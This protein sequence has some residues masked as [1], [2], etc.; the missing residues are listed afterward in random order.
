MVGILTQEV[1]R[2][3]RKTEKS[4]IRRDN[5]KFGIMCNNLHKF[6]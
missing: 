1:A 5:K 6:L 4:Q 2:G 3:D